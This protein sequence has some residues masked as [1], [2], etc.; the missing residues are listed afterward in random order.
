MCLF[1]FTYFQA[2]ISFVY[3]FLFVFLYTVYSTYFMVI[4][5]AFLCTRLCTDLLESQFFMYF[6][7][8][9]FTHSFI[10][11]LFSFSHLLLVIFICVFFLITLIMSLL[12][13]SFKIFTKL[14]TIY[15]LTYI[16]TFTIFI[17]YLLIIFY[18]FIILL[19]VM[20]AQVRLGWV[21]LVQ[22]FI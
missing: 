2:H 7:C 12:F 13:Y 22:Q 4:S 19:Q 14:D 15:S 11:H 6:L 18:S 5:G 9:T 21:E 1:I 3:I 16:H 8:S 17:Y 20:L 10:S